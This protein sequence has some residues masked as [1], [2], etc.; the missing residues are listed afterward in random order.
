MRNNTDLECHVPA[1]LMELQC[2]ILQ[3]LIYFKAPFL[4][5]KVSRALYM[6]LSAIYSKRKINI[7]LQIYKNCQLK[8]T[9]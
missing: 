4:R 5:L 9:I 7:Y 3:A 6:E 1:K 8:I 2:G